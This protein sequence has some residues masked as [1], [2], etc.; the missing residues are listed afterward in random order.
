MKLTFDFSE[1]DCLM[2]RGHKVSQ[3]ILRHLRSYDSIPTKP[4]KK[5]RRTGMLDF[6]KVDDELVDQIWDGST[7]MW[8]DEFVKGRQRIDKTNPM[9][10]DNN[11]LDEI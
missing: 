10:I 1:M 9:R 8:F 4:T 2:S 3:R 6:G 7:T 5:H 11:F